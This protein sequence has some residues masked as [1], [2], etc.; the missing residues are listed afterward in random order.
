MNIET[1]YRKDI[2]QADNPLL[3]Y[4]L[5]TK[6]LGNLG[7]LRADAVEND[8]KG[9]GRRDDILQYQDYH[10][11]LE[12]ECFQDQD[13]MLTCMSKQF[14]TYEKN[15]RTRRYSVDFDAPTVEPTASI[16]DVVGDKLTR[17]ESSDQQGLTEL[18]RRLLGR[19]QSMVLEPGKSTDRQIE[20]QDNLQNELVHDMTK[21]VGSLRQGATAFQNALEEDRFVLDAAEIG[22]Q[23]ASRSLTD[24]GDKL[25]RYDRKKLGYLFYI[26]ATLSMIIGLLV[27]FVIIKLF[28]AL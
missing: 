15:Q 1:R 18:R 12:F 24:I 21:L 8:L 3:S 6:H 25:K 22:V 17:E 14:S 27:T 26:L 20:D 28:P 4:L 5:N 23:V 7:V 16:D 19:R 2:Q 9:Y 13:E 10:R 11:K